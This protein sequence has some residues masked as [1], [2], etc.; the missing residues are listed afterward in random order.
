MKTTKYILSVIFAALHFVAFSQTATL[1]STFDIQKV[2][3]QTVPIQNNIPFPSFEKQSRNS[4][5]LKGTWKKLRFNADD[6]ITLAKRDENGLADILTEAG[7]IEDKNYDDSGW[8]SITIPSVENTMNSYQKR[9]EYYE[10]G[11]WYRKKVN[12]SA[13]QSSGISR[14][15]FLAVNYIA[16]V[17]INGKYL[18]WHEGGY[19]PFSFDL[20]GCL[21]EGE[22]TIVVRVD[23]PEWGTRKDIVPYTKADWFNYTGIIHDVYIEFLPDVSIV[24]TDVVSTE[25]NGD[26]TAKIILWNPKKLNKTFDLNLSLSLPQFS[27]VNKSTEDFQTVTASAVSA[28]GKTSGS[29]NT[30]GDSIIAV[31]MNFNISNVK[32]WTPKK[33]AVY[34][35]NSKLTEASV[36]S[37]NFFTQFG[38]R[39]I[40]TDNRQLKL[41][42]QN[43]FMAGVARHEDH[44]VYGR[45]I[46]KNIIYSDFQ[47]IKATNSTIVRTAHYPNHPYSYLITDRL[48]LGVIEEIPV[49]WFD[50]AEAFSIQNNTRHIHEQMWREMIF[51]D[52]NRPSIFFW[53]S[54]NE[55]LDVQGRK[56]YIETIRDDMNNNYPNNRLIIQSAATDRPGVND[57]SQTV[58]DAMGWTMYFGVFYGFDYYED[59][60]T[61]L[62]SALTNHPNKSVIATEFG[63][64][65]KEDHSEQY[66]QD[67]VFSKTFNAFKEYSTV[68]TNGT[69]N[70]DGNLSVVIWWCMY[71]WY[72]H[73][74]PT[75]FQSM[76]LYQMNRTSEKTVYSVLKS[77]YFPYSIFFPTS[78][79]PN[80]N[81]INDKNLTVGQNYP[82]PFNPETSIEFELNKQ[83]N[84]KVILFNILGQQ[85]DIIDL[86]NQQ[87]GKHTINLALAKI[88]ANISSGVLFY[89]IEADNFSETKKMI[90]TK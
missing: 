83:A 28:T 62:A 90:F 70:Q 88:A 48:G 86:G 74:L 1:E 17:W 66:V 16:D 44:P 32:W 67:A 55:C 85:L 58:C 81:I 40:E 54:A 21:T 8:G 19:T 53:S 68:L 39:K 25:L 12:V 49:W 6:K 7:G 22:N 3:N 20:T 59:T 80:E 51:R 50:D 63:K 73:T 9:P 72:T 2:D 87:R 71:D 37:D 46:P 38:V 36:V 69:T 75:G 61:F 14:L 29:V 82:N 35:L 45:S 84:V 26:V 52:W 77:A 5:D 79:Q 76:G 30:N 27:D 78:V 41:N 11:V 4:I 13:E 42:N 60:K 56:N 18:G 64:W 43:A 15:N 33:P 89:R 24:R 10:N 34:F 47:Q 23:N 31:T 57:D 65:S